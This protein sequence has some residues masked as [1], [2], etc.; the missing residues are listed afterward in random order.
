[1]DFFL[2]ILPNIIKVLILPVAV[3]S[4]GALTVFLERRLAGLIQGRLGPNRVGPF[5]IGILIADMIKTFW[6]EDI[7]PERVDKVLFIIAPLLSFSTGMITFAIIPFAALN[8]DDVHAGIMGVDINVGILWFLSFA[9]MAVYGVAYGG[10]ASNNKYS[11]FGGLR[12][13]AQLV[14]F[15]IAMALTLVSIIMTCGAVHVNEIVLQQTYTD[16]QTKDLFLGFLPHWLVFK[17]PLAFILFVAAGFGEINRNPF[18]L[19]EA[20]QELVGGYY[21]EYSSWK[22]GSFMFADY[23]SAMPFSALVVSLFFGGWHFPYLEEWVEPGVWFALASFLVFSIKM[24][25]WIFIIIWIRWTIPR[26]RY[27]Q[28]MRLGWRAMIPLAVLNIVLT[29]IFSRTDLFF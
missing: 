20:E 7:F 23:V 10:W 14:S 15:E 4:G 25:I 28:F 9:S 29:S 8:I 26:F 22:F 21:T 1:M 12:S 5:G 18:D 6:K 13:I 24:A 11:L 3:V 17:Q 19:P 2:E 27:D 16:P